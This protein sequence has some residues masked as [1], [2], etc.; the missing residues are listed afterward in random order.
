MP[1]ADAQFDFVWAKF[2][3]MNI[4]DK[5]RL[6]A[7]QR[8]VAARPGGRLI[9]EP[10][11]VPALTLCARCVAS[12]VP[13]RSPHNPLFSR[14]GVARLRDQLENGSCFLH[15]TGRLPTGHMSQHCRHESLA[16]SRPAT[17]GQGSAEADGG[18]QLEGPRMLP[19]CNAQCQLE[20]A[21]GLGRIRALHYRHPSL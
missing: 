15:V 4:R 2:A 17:V 13:G 14:N 10:S 6:V 9:E 3:S 8:R 7:E 21:F 5:A 18:S 12:D 11:P 20:A 1:F 16:F 19:L